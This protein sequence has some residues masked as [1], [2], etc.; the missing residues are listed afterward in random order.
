MILERTDSESGQVYIRFNV[1]LTFAA[2]QN[3]LSEQVQHSKNA[4]IDE[5]LTEFLA[6]I[7]PNA[8]VIID[9]SECRN[10][11]W[12][13]SGVLLLIKNHLYKVTRN[14]SLTHCS[15]ELIKAIHAGGLAQYFNIDSGNVVPFRAQC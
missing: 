7:H 12:S 6:N 8:Q 5:Q 3:A 13:G 1:D 11:D 15:K 4:T 10:L 14:I 2:F 9:L